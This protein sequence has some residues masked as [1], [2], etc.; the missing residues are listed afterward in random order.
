MSPDLLNP[1]LF[2]LKDSRPTKKSDCYALGMVVL[3]VLS[4]RPPF[5]SD[6]DFIVMR[7][8]MNGEHPGRPEGAWF[9]DFLWGMLE[10]CWAARP[11]SRP[12]IEAVVVHLE[13]ASG[14]WEPPSQDVRD[15][16]VDQDDL[17]HGIVS[18]RFVFILNVSLTL[19]Q[20]LLHQ[21][22]FL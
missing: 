5:A 10:Q 18:G 21:A 11:E 1:E 15:V 14:A 2:G 7:K 19:H 22:L 20:D 6:K 3:E 16:G 17:N 13:R 9:T 12:S 8:I 4:S